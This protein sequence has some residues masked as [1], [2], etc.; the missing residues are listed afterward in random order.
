MNS[1]QWLSYFRIPQESTYFKLIFEERTG[2]F[3]LISTNTVNTRVDQPFAV[4]SSGG[5]RF[6]V[7]CDWHVG[8]HFPFS[9][10]KRV[11]G[12]NR[13]D[14]ANR[15]RPV[16][17]PQVKPRHIF[18]AL[19]SKHQYMYIYNTEYMYIWTPYW[20]FGISIFL[21]NIIFASTE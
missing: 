13:N 9:G 11:K 12:P 18:Y 21:K 10:R 6:F 2:I 3:P 20:C 17:Q 14:N 16:R 1:G 5:T 15:K 4:K 8:P 19:I 7:G